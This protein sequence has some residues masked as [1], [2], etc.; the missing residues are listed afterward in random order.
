[1]S[2]ILHKNIEILP[3]KSNS[4]PDL[5][6]QKINKIQEVQVT[7]YNNYG[8]GEGSTIRATDLQISDF[9]QI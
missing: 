5:L 1:M 4:S 6:I 7:F 9:S 2:I 8:Q 3:I